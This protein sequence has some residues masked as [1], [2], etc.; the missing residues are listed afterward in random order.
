MFF[1][2][3]PRKRFAAVYLAA[4]AAGFALAE[5][6]RSILF[7]WRAA[8]TAGVYDIPFHRLVIFST[9]LLTVVLVPGIVASLRREP[10]PAVQ[11]GPDGDAAISARILLLIALFFLLHGL[12]NSSLLPFLASSRVLE[13][14]DVLALTSTADNGDLPE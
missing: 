10:F 5:G 6:Q 8:E 14:V 3:V 12:T 7:A 13:N 2:L 11:N 4:L 1:T 9:L